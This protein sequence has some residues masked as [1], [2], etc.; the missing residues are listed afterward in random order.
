M[1]YLCEREEPNLRMEQL[2]RPVILKIVFFFYG[3]L[4]SLRINSITVSQKTITEN[5]Q[6]QS[7]F[8]PE[9]S[10]CLILSTCYLSLFYCFFFIMVLFKVAFVWSLL[11]DPCWQFQLQRCRQQPTAGF[12]WSNLSFVFLYLCIKKW[13]N[14]NQSLLSNLENKFYFLLLLSR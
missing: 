5:I 11:L 3:G 8:N 2:Y 12:G 4:K 7:V 6:L 9:I 13:F 1:Y 14:Q 10:V